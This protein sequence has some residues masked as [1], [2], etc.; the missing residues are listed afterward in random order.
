MLL[1]ISMTWT[2]LC[3]TPA[4]TDDSPTRP[5]THRREPMGRSITQ[6][7]VEYKAYTLAEYKQLGHLILDYHLLWD[8]SLSLELDISSYE[9]E[10]VQWEFRM[11]TWKEATEAQR[12]RGD[13]LS[14][15][16][17]EEHELRL[18]LEKQ[19]KAFGWVPWALVVVESIAIGVL[20]VYS[21]AKL[22]A[23]D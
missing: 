13:I 8:Y 6:D 14:K 7:G 21:G 2:L 15:M 1:M 4:A 11:N 18:G 10:T 22:A 19:H 9:R 20:G 5:D 12:A 3:A 16:F 23:I 17:D